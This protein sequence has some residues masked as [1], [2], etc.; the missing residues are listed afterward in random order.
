MPGVALALGANA[1]QLAVTD[2][3]GLSANVASPLTRVAQTQADAVL[4][5]TDIALQQPSSAT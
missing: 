5:W 2:A 3:G 4:D 1:L